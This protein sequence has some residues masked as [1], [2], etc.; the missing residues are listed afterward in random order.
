MLPAG[1]EPSW[2]RPVVLD[3]SYET[4]HDARARVAELDQEVYYT[5]P[6]EAVRPKYVVVESVIAD[7]L[8]NR[9]LDDY[10]WTGW[11]QSCQSPYD[12]PCGECSWCINM[13]VSQDREFV[14]RHAL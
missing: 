11:Q 14:L 4:L 13:I 3:E 5:L 2:F 1:Y 9:P 10:D 12:E 7:L 8:S 6:G